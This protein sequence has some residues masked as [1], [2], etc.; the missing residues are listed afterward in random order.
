MLSPEIVIFSH[1]RDEHA[2]AVLRC[3]PGNCTPLIIDL[4][5][6]GCGLVGSLNPSVQGGVSL[7]LPSG[8]GVCLQSVQSVW[9]RRPT[10]LSAPNKCEER[11]KSFLECEQKQFL[12]GLISL[13]PKGVKFFNHPD[14]HAKMDRKAYQ[15]WCA[16]EVGFLIP[17]TCITSDSVTAAEFLDKVGETIYK[18][19]WGTEE[20]WQPTRRVDSDIIGNLHLLS[21]GPV[22]FQEYV[23]GRRDIRVTFVDGYVE[24][25]AFDLNQS[26]YKYDVRIDTKIEAVKYS[27]PPDVVDK[28][29]KFCT[30]AGLNYAAIDLRERT[31]GE[32]VFFEVN[33]AGQFL[34]L[35]YLAGTDLVGIFSSSLSSSHR[36]PNSRKSVIR[37]G[38]PP[39]LDV[40]IPL[41]AVGAE[42][43]HLT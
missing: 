19:F 9:W 16:T 15:L 10:Y 31:D 30:N 27:L 28:V 11:Y 38:S 26:R 32:F 2:Q 43:S 7:R 4:R 41:N 14:V 3:L 22:I 33:P 29:C 39:F 40:T 8:E 35:D 25:V 37:D 21:M 17:A 12:D 1:A 24:A 5:D 23:D 20:F 13:M 6:F 42:I 34:Y 36:S 18:S